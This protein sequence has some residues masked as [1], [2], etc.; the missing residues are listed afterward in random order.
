MA[1]Y[2]PY[3]VTRRQNSGFIGEMI[4]SMEKITIEAMGN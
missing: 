3:L 1:K 2:A 4:A